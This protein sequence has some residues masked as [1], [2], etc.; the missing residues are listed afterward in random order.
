M[1]SSNSSLRTA[2]I[3]VLVIILIIIVISAEALSY[4]DLIGVDKKYR[5]DLKTTYVELEK[6]FSL[7]SS[8]YM[9]SLKYYYSIIEP[10]LNALS[11]S[12]ALMKLPQTIIYPILF[13]VIA[14]LSMYSLLREYVS[15]NILRIIGSI[16]YSFNPAVTFYY[17]SFTA[18]FSIAVLPLVI[19]YFIKLLNTI[20]S[21]NYKE[22][23][24]NSLFFSIVFIIHVSAHLQILPVTAYILS[25]SGIFY[26]LYKIN[27]N[28]SVR[29]TRLATNATLAVLTLTLLSAPLLLTFYVSVKS[30]PTN[31]LGGVDPNAARNDFLYIYNVS[32]VNGIALSGDRST[33]SN[34]LGY[35]DLRN[36]I[37]IAGFAYF[38]SILALIPVLVKSGKDE[39]IIFILMYLITVASLISI[40]EL[41]QSGYVDLLA[42]HRVF[43]T[44]RSPIKLRA[45]GFASAIPATI[46]FLDLIKNKINNKIM[47][48]YFIIILIMILIYSSPV[49]MTA[50]NVPP[51]LKPIP[52]LTEIT[53]WIVENTE[54]S[55]HGIVLP[56]DHWT[57]I[58]VPP[59]FRLFPMNTNLPII[60]LI[61]Q[62]YEQGIPLSPLLKL[63][64]IKYVV[65]D[66]NWEY[67]RWSILLS[68]QYIDPWKLDKYL[69]KDKDLMLIYKS[70]GF[71]VYEV[72][73]SLPLEYIA[74]EFIVYND[75]GCLLKLLNTTI[76]ASENY[77]I[78]SLNDINKNEIT[79]KIGVANVSVYLIVKHEEKVSPEDLGFKNASILAVFDDN[80]YT[81]TILRVN[82]TEF[83]NIINLNKRILYVSKRE[84]AIRVNSSYA[85]LGVFTGFKLEA[86]ASV[87]KPGKYSWKTAIIRIESTS[88]DYS[89]YVIFH[90]NGWLEIAEKVNGVYK[91]NVFAK[92]VGFN[93]RNIT[94]TINYDEESKKINISINK[95]LE[96]SFMVKYNGPWRVLLGA[97]DSEAVYRNVNLE[98]RISAIKYAALIM[99]SSLKM[100]VYQSMYNA[101]YT[102]RLS[103]SSNLSVV[104]EKP[105]LVNGFSNGWFVIGEN[106]SNAEK[107]T[108]SY[109]FDRVVKIIALIYYGLIIVILIIFI[110][111]KY[112]TKFIY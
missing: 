13:Y 87:E 64:S 102:V 67:A 109:P 33:I 1:G 107:A 49:M 75:D 112:R 73:D 19:K 88:S 2:Y 76:P 77:A 71:N 62:A 99:D 94:A 65:I 74:E 101:G 16:L 60:M 93:P 98:G 41:V 3:E 92:K 23:I 56:Y 46:M 26:I 48:I 15:S 31:Y 111:N 51:D 103:L 40:I 57:E 34:K 44:L 12:L 82:K 47:K 37:T 86:L 20:I 38:Y 53:N 7:I 18:P 52:R 8:E 42:K 96:V 110:I 81:Y 45:F 27:K 80:G 90:T 105:V 22:L 59:W 68:S 84:E 17:P 91:P 83:N 14:A 9:N 104:N 69:E 43:H 72:K 24:K 35:N 106:A 6:S 55:E 66:K 108:V 29:L 11:H 28:R 78:I 4:Q 5:S 10:I 79:K 85:N 32:N 36:P 25:V 70:R 21:N 100:I 30:S 50:A 95:V 58:H 39:G 61:E 54:P 89:V 63:A 97:D